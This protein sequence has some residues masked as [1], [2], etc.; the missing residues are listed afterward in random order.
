[1]KIQLTT[2]IALLLS[3]HGT[4]QTNSVTL[5]SNEAYFLRQHSVANATDQY[6]IYGTDTLFFEAS[7]NGSIRFLH[8]SS[9]ENDRVQ[10]VDTI[11]LNKDGVKELFVF[12]K[13]SCEHLPPSINEFCV[14][15][16][17]N[18]YE[19]YEVWDIKNHRQIFEFTSLNRY[20][21]IV[22]TNVV[23]SGGFE[24]DVRIN[25]KG[26]IQ[27]E[28]LNTMET[29]ENTEGTYRYDAASGTYILKK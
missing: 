8:P 15:C 1:M 2:F 21:R 14:G 26:S 4:A 11:D 16:E 10:I 5:D 27:F 7:C 18:W 19:Q 28:K 20:Q 6:L 22:S 3:L 17:T 9:L 24:Y 12:R 29:E 23:T 25:N 13:W